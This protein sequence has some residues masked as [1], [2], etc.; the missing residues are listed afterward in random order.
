MKP[1]LPSIRTLPCFRFKP[2]KAGRAFRALC[3]RCLNYDINP[4]MGIT[5]E[6]LNVVLILTDDQGYWALGSAGN[7]EI[8]TPH[9]DRLAARGMYFDNFFCASPICSPAGG[10]GSSSRHVGY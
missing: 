3:L 5:T 4:N 1:A 9:L 7:T 10:N 8:R 6:K 2:V